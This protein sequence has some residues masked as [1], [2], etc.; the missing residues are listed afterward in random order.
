MLILIDKILG[1]DICSGLSGKNSW[2]IIFWYIIA[3][4]KCSLYDFYW[5]NS[6]TEN[7]LL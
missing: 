5:C 6:F 7:G 4:W 1:W 3:V 2:M